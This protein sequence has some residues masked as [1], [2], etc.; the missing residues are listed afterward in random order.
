MS[1]NQFINPLYNQFSCVELYGK[2][3]NQINW[4][5][6]VTTPSFAMVFLER[7][8]I[9][10]ILL[11]RLAFICLILELEKFN[12]DNLNH[13]NKNEFSGF[14]QNTLH[15]LSF[16]PIPYFSSRPTLISQ[17]LQCQI[18]QIANS[19]LDRLTLMMTVDVVV[20][21]DI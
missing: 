8:I 13:I 10:T 19:Y 11:D 9:P 3:N 12:S 20:A 14:S 6:T 2:N 17:S 7:M 15:T 21:V 1:H 5:L 4:I 18:C 16:S